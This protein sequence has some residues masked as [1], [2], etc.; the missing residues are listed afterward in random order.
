MPPLPLII[1]RRAASR[2]SEPS[3]DGHPFH[4]IPRVRLELSMQIL[5]SVVN[6]VLHL[7][8]KIG[9]VRRRVA[10]PVGTI[11]PHPELR[12]RVRR[13]AALAPAGGDPFPVPRLDNL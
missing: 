4:E 13:L 1:I 12:L 9:S 2:P 7:G 5:G 10:R 11:S 6:A 3:A 8:V